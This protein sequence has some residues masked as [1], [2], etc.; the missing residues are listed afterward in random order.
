MTA[1]P[2]A[3]DRDTAFV[4]AAMSDE[5]GSLER[6]YRDLGYA[7]VNV[8][9]SNGESAL[10]TAAVSGHE[11]NMLWYVRHACAGN[12]VTTSTTTRPPAL[13]ERLGACCELW[14]CLSQPVE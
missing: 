13:G 10:H 8:V 11:S 5:P 7:N 12:A 4:L 9:D 2:T 3:S 14:L 1:E 6:F